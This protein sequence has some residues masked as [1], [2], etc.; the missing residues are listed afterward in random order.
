MATLRGLYKH[1]LTKTAISPCHQGFQSVNNINPP[2]AQLIL[3]QCVY[4]KAYGTYTFP[5]QTPTH[6][7]CVPFPLCCTLEF[8]SD[9]LRPNLFHGNRWPDGGPTDGHLIHDD[10]LHVPRLHRP[11]LQFYQHTWDGLHPQKEGQHHRLPVSTEE[12]RGIRTGMGIEW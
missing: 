3:G 11:H 4:L 8:A 10:W 9:V 5:S 6:P 7:V 12:H 1:C 2:Y